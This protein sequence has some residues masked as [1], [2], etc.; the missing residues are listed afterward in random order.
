MV[1][2]DVVFASP[3]YQKPFAL[4]VDV[5]IYLTTEHLYGQGRWLVWR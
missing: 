3:L 2:V 5:M 4:G 1:M